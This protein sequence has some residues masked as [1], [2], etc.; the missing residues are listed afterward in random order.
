MYAPPAGP[1]LRAGLSLG[2]SATGAGT[3][4]S[5]TGLRLLSG[6]DSLGRGLPERL[7]DSL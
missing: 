5:A 7:S 1:A 2:G 4:G 3:G 6:E